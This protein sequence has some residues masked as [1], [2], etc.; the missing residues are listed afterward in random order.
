MEKPRKT[1]K[2]DCNFLHKIEKSGEKGDCKNLQKYPKSRVK[3]G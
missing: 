3:A 1:E 2:V